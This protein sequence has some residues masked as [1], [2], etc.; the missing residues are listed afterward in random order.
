[1]DFAVNRRQNVQIKFFDRN[2]TY[3]YAEYKDMLAIIVQHEYD[4]LKGKLIID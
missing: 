3:R 4:H 2:W 1:M